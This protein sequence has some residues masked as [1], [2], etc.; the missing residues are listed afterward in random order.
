MQEAHAEL[1]ELE[2][3]FRRRA[4]SSQSELQKLVESKEKREQ[5][6]YIK[7]FLILLCQL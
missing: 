2:G 5:E 4:D 7:V 6:L 1:A 3:K